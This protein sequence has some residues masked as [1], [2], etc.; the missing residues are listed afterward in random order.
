MGNIQR[1]GK[2]YPI[3]QVFEVR[4]HCFVTLCGKWFLRSDYS[5]VQG[6]VT[7]KQCLNRTEEQET[8]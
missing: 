4:V 2:R 3:H 8:R 1:K 5:N 7:C 6:E